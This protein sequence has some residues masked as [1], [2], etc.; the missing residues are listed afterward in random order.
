[1][2]AKVRV[3]IANELHIIEGDQKLSKNG[4]EWIEL[5]NENVLKFYGIVYDMGFLPAIITPYCE[6]G[7]ILEYLNKSS[8]TI[9]HIISL[10]SGSICLNFPID[11]FPHRF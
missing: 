2:T 1:M 4:L 5:D 7:N 6:N 11:W 8:L 9:S 3:R 10:V